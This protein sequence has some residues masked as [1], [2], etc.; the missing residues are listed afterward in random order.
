MV[1]L[2]NWFP[3]N[4]RGFVV[5]VWCALYMILPI[6][7]ET[8]KVNGFDNFVKLFDSL[9]TSHI[10]ESRELHPWWNLF[11]ASNNLPL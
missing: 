6:I 4:Y 9:L 5:G 11:L 2:Y 1:I 7:Y 10:I 3:S 8:S